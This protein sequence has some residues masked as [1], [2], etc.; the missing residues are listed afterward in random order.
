[1]VKRTLPSTLVFVV[2]PLALALACGSSDGSDS[3]APAGSAT[4]GSTGGVV[5]GAGVRLT[6]PEGAIEQGVTIAI[7]VGTPDVAP[8]DGY[9]AVSP[10]YVFT[11]DGL[12]FQKPVTIE[13]P[14][15]DGIGATDAIVWSSDKGG[16]EDL[17][18]AI[19]PR[20]M[21]ASVVHF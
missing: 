18:S 10:I 20:V 13:I 3:P 6:V 4:V 21:T 7:A 19:G 15:P 9:V 5:E 12:V 1:M 17:P 11:P 14:L 8:P 2:A 16:V